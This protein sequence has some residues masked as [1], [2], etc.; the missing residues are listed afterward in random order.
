[1]S[2]R[3]KS[4]ASA[5]GAARATARRMD[6][7]KWL[8]SYELY[9]PMVIRAANTRAT[10]WCTSTIAARIGPDTFFSGAAGRR[11]PM[12]DLDATDQYPRIDRSG[13]F[14]VM[15]PYL[16]NF[17]TAYEAAATAKIKRP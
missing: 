9:N 4:K 8:A 13:M 6:S 10:R 16:A 11:G 2:A 15:Q 17:I 14:Q 5:S 7:W 1:M 12:T 3:W